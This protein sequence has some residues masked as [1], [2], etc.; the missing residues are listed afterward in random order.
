[1]NEIM[2]GQA[3]QVQMAAYLTA[4][5]IKGENIDEIPHPPPECAPTVSSCSMTWMYLGLSA[6]AGRRKLF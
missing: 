1:M 5:S 2:E 3:S 6:P 4:L